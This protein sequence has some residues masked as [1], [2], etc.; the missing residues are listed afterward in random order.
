MPWHP[1]WCILGTARQRED[2]MPGVG[3][4]AGA[5]AYLQIVEWFENARVPRTR[6]KAPLRTVYN[7]W[8]QRHEEIPLPEFQHL[9]IQGKIQET[10]DW[11]RDDSRSRRVYRLV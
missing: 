7:A 4:L 10:I 2:R 9:L 11:S 5:R 6:E 8:T 1:A 3:G